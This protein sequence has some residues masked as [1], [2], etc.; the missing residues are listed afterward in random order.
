MPESEQVALGLNGLTEDQRTALAVLL[1][2]YYFAGLNDAVQ[3][4]SVSGSFEGWDGDTT[5]ERGIAPGGRKRPVRSIL[6]GFGASGCRPR[7]F[8]AARCAA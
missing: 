8:P 5:L 6:H 1:T 2:G 4:S 7:L 3:Q